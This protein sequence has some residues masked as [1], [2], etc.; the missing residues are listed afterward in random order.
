MPAAQ[1]CTHGSAPASAMAPSTHSS[2]ADASGGCTA[3]CRPKPD[4]VGTLRLQHGRQRR[5]VHLHHQP[6]DA[7]QAAA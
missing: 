3:R 4:A 7:R 1:E 2:A 6:V 5:L